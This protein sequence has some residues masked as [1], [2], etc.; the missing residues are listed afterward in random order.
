MTN[1]KEVFLATNGC[2]ENG[3]D[4]ARM[5][6]FL[7][8]NDWTVTK[9]VEDADLILFNACGLTQYTEDISI[10]IINQLKARK[11]PSAE[12]IAF[13][14]LPRIN[15]E[16]FREAYQGFTFGSDEIEGITEIIE[17]KSSGHDVHANYLIPSITDA[18]GAKWKIPNLKKLGSLME[19][20]NSVMMESY[21]R[22][23]SVINVYRPYSFLIKVATGCSRACAFCACPEPSTIIRG[24]W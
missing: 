20:E 23:C 12:L 7:I 18:G 8:E 6:E 21:N 10:K 2:P 1:K 13:G 4:L 14:C 15:K 17:T 19:I 5:Q 24:S 11:K 9:T 3:I 22:V 16:R